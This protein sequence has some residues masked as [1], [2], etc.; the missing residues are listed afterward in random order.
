MSAA[1]ADA[2]APELREIRGPSAFG[3]GTRRFFD[4]LWLS[5]MAELRR[6]YVG[7]VLGYLWTLLRP[8]LFFAILYVV[9]TKVFRF[10][11]DVPNY[12]VFLILNLMLFEF[13]AEA[14]S[15]ATRSV[16]ESENVVRKMQFPRIVIPLAV[17]LTAA[18]TLCLNLLA[19][20]AVMLVLGV[21]AHA[22]W[23]LLPLILLV[24]VGFTTGVAL[25]LSSLFVG[26]RDIEHFWTV[27]LRALLY[28]LPILYPIEFV[29]EGAL[30]WV[31]VANPLTP[32]LEQTRLWVTDPGAPSVADAA[33]STALAVAPLVLLVALPA[34][35]L[36]FFNRQAPRIAEAL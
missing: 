6:R 19:A 30:R 25:V 7:S 32:I 26:F 20:F 35:G 36:W 27:G 8:L 2:L 15:G 18:M 5:A 21:E 31:V 34:I 13:F 1:T 9:F 23:L 10:G 11:D 4:L 33:G 17:V 28:G 12:A 29:P 16:L 22:T 24:L 3:G 14:T